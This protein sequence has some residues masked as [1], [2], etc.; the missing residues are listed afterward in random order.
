MKKMKELIGFGIFDE[1]G[2]DLTPVSTI[3]IKLNS[4]GKK[5]RSDL[6]EE[7][8]LQLDNV[9]SVLLIEE[10]KE[11][12]MEFLDL[13]FTLVGVMIVLSSLI[14]VSTVFT[15]VFHNIHERKRELV[16]VQV[17][18]MTDQELI[19]SITVE[20]LIIGIIAL[21]LGFPTGILLTQLIINSL[22]PVMLYF[23]VSIHLLTLLTVLL[24]PLTSILLA[25]YPALKYLFKLELTDITKEIIN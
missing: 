23:E 12:I 11:G 18:G 7:I 24:I 2:V 5:V 1:I 10:I 15:V 8:L 17:L 21:I 3:F 22:F 19:L 25:E 4:E 14:A 6:R 13:F 20:N 16:T 9:Q